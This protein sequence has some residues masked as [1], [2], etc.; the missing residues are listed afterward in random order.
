[1]TAA[2]GSEM[3]FPPGRLVHARLPMMPLEPFELRDHRVA[4]RDQRVPVVWESARHED[5]D[6]VP[7]GS[8]LLCPVISG[9]NDQIV[10]YFSGVADALSRNP[11]AM[12]IAQ[13]VTGCLGKLSGIGRLGNSD[14]Q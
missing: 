10:N 9:S 1:V 6:K 11:A 5:L 8:R 2:D 14:A 4:G 13:Q 7:V 12:R 3:G